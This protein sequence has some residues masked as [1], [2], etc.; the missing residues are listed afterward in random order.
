MRELALGYRVGVKAMGKV[1]LVMGGDEKTVGEVL[2]LMGENEGSVAISGDDTRTRR[3]PK[4]VRT[5][6]TSTQV[7]CAFVGSC[8]SPT[9]AHSYACCGRV[10]AYA[11]TYIYRYM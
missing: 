3:P 11:S 4:R 10:S 5:C 6:I 9:S 7:C 1:L 8:V 2:L